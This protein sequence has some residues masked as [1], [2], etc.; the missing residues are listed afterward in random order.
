MNPFTERIETIAKIKWP[1]DGDG[2]LE[3]D[4]GALVFGGAKRKDF[5]CPDDDWE[6][7]IKPGVDIK[8]WDYRLRITLLQIFIDHNWKTFWY[9]GNDFQTKAEREASEKTYNDFVEN[10]AI[11]IKEMIDSGESFY[12]I[13]Q[14]MYGKGHTGFTSG[15]CI[16][17]A[18]NTATNSKHAEVIRKAWNKDCGQTSNGVVNPAVMSI[19]PKGREIIDFH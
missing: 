4:C 13:K 17:G 19:S 5:F 11:R 10:E 7:I 14:S 9:C 3:I 15:C 8:F 1:D 18:I 2:H 6:S 16:N 12:D